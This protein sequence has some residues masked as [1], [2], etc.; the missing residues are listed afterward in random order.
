MWN[1]NCPMKSW[2]SVRSTI[3][4]KMRFVRSM[5][6]VGYSPLVTMDSAHHMLTYACD[7]PGSDKPFWFVDW[8]LCHFAHI[9]FRIDLLG[10]EGDRVVEQSRRLSM[11][12]RAMHQPYHY[13]KV[14]RSIWKKTDAS[15]D[16]QMWDLSLEKTRLTN[17]SWSIFIIYP[18]WKMIIREINCLSAES[19]TN[20]L[21]DDICSFTFSSVDP[22]CMQ[23]WCSV[24]QAAFTYDRKLTVGFRWT[25]S[26]WPS[27]SLCPFSHSYAFLVQIWGT[28]DLHLCRSC[29]RS[30]MGYVLLPYRRIALHNRSLFSSSQFSVPHTWWWNHS[31]C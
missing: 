8:E 17:T 6:S 4:W 21:S 10:L 12:G 31:D 23:V 15:I 27:L 1:T 19:R 26:S 13:R 2:R 28:T 25:H 18:F 5:I 7:T 11:A 3:E 29:S 24:E 16:I 20:E 30:S 14:S 22:N 9:S